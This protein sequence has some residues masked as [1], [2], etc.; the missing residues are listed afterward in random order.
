M[1]GRA[2]GDAS[3]R[4]RPDAAAPPLGPRHVERVRD[5]R[6][7]H[8]QSLDGRVAPDAAKL[9]THERVELGPVSVGIDDRVAQAAAQLSGFSLTVGRHGRSSVAMRCRLDHTPERLDHA[10][11]LD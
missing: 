7:R 1:R 4:L 10:G 8:V 2:P 5:A 3:H 11:R 6:A 9:L